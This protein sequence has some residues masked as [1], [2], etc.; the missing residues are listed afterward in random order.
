M[1]QQSTSF[2]PYAMGVVF[3]SCLSNQSL[4]HEIGHIQGSK[5]DR[6]NSSFQGVYPY[7]YGF[8]RC[9]TDGTGFRTVMS[10]DCGGVPRVLYFSNP[11]ISYNGYATGISYEMDPAN[12]AENARSISNTASTVAA[13][14]SSTST[15]SPTATPA[16]PTGMKVQSASYSQ[17]N[18]AWTDNATNETGYKVERSL[19][20]ATF[21]QVATL[22]ADSTGYADTNVTAKS[23]YY[24]RVRAYNSAG[25]SGYSSTVS[26]TTPDLPPPAPAAPTSVS[27]QNNADGTATVSWT[28]DPAS[29]ATSFEVRREKWD[30]RKLAWGSATTAATVPASLLSIVDSTGAG[31]FR[32]S[33]RATNSGGA[34]GYAGPV[35][36]DVTASSTKPKGKSGR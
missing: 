27:P 36:V 16:A 15:P 14:R 35:K 21:A 12:S 1:T 4:V 20:G 22:G 7:G 3:S 30:L 24:Y 10:Y 11:N 19:D 25:D 33:V 32:Y 18:T 31:T 17:V 13:F 6:A 9:T 34:S 28:V 5:H 8:R 23:T 26:V 2:A 29:T